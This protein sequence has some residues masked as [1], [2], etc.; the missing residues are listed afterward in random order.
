MSISI[1]IAEMAMFSILFT[2]IGFATTGKKSK[3]QI[4][5]YPPEIQEEYFKTHKRIAVQPLSGRVIAIKSIGILI[6]TGIL[7]ICAYAV[8]AEKFV[9]GFGIAFGLMVWIG[10]YDTFFLDWVLFANMK[11]FRL[12]GT[13]HMDK[14][15]H[16]KWFHVKGMLFPGIIF[17]LIPSALVGII[18]AVI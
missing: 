9:E 15:Y 6:F 13:E 1:I 5:N 11:R 17:A 3:L 4:H 14:E 10:A 12:E 16:Q 8:G 18:I 2:V 7:T